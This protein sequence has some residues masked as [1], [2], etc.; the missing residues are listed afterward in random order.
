VALR[1]AWCLGL[2]PAG[3]GPRPITS[4][5]MSHLVDSLER[6]Y[7]VLGSRTRR[8]GDE[9]FRRLVLARIMIIEPSSKLGSL[10]VLKEAG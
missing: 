4:S 1:V 7:R 5:K 10:R 2:E 6:A 8:A 3:G 9:V